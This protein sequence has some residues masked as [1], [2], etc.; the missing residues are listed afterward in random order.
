MMKEENLKGKIC[1]TFPF[2]YFIHFS[3]VFLVKLFFLW[4]CS[5]GGVG[6]VVATSTTVNPYHV[7]TVTISCTTSTIRYYPY[8]KKFLALEKHMSF[9]MFVVS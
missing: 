3:Y 4:R 8:I 6:D 5:G 2:L 9:N 1:I 7:I